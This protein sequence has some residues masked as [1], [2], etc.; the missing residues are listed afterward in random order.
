VIRTLVACLI[1]LMLSVQTAAQDTPFS[2]LDVFQVEYA[3]DVQIAPDG[4]WV[5]YVRNS[6]SI[7]RDRREGRLWMVRTDQS[8]HRQLT[9]GDQT[10]SSPRW[11]PDGSRIAFVTRGDDGA[12]I[13]V[14]WVATGESARLTQLDRSPHDIAWS[15][16]GNFLAFSK[17]VPEAS[18]RLA[19][20]PPRPDGAQWADAPLVE[21]RVHH[22]SDGSGFIE[23]GYN[24]LFV[25]PAD[26]GTPR[27][28]TTGDFHHGSP[29]WMPDGRSILFSANRNPDW[30]YERRESDIYSV[31]VD[32]GDNRR[33]TD[34]RGP[35]SSPAVAPDGSLVAYVGFD[36]RIQTY[37]TT[38]LYFMRSDG[39]R[40]RMVLEDL[41]RSVGSPTWAN[42]GSGVY[43]S[44]DDEGISKVGFV[45]P[46]GDFRVV[47]DSLGGTA[48]GRPYGGG[49]F[50]VA[51]DGS[52]AY[53]FTTSANPS[54]VGLSSPHGSRSFLTALN[55]DLKAQRQIAAAEMF[56]TESSHDGRPVQSW[57]VFPPDFDPSQQYPLILEIHGGPISNYGDRFSAEVQL[58][59]TAG[60]VVV[61]SNPR[62]S[63]S[64]GAEFGNL[65]YHDYPG[66][67]YDDLMSAVDAVIDRGYI[68][69]D[70]LYVTGGSA[71]GIMTAW[72]VGKTHRFRAAVVTKPV[73]N[74]ISKTLVA[75]NYD[76]YMD[77]R[78]PGKP[79]ENPM[80]YW[81]FSPL[82]LVSNI[83]TPTMVMVGTADLR[84]PLSEAKQ[85]YH[86]LKL[87]RVETALV[88]IPGAYHNISNR[89]SQLIA[90]VL[91]AIAWFDRYGG[92]PR[93][94]SD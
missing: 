38:N 88:Q 2:D 5:V 24:H 81:E 94:A 78:Y 33:L 54:E 64:Y 72:I 59:A 53:T 9:S 29:V 87:R 76:G 80:G 74:W 3:S 68:D 51:R 79:W 31:P 56:W 50:S 36:D 28:I 92:Q 35:D 73:V 27:Q 22:E 39:S 86:A 75:D 34:R 57:V 37:Q 47:A 4:D 65:L 85:L 77:Y 61:Y 15:P 32:D 83:E 7:M 14:Y 40:S 20:L 21:T 11:S 70:R 55:E 8:E 17:L 82:S 49:N 12:E 1:C 62:G 19:A 16:D 52:V 67:D 44:Y 48:V 46:E 69:E 23:P 71:G 91:H 60:F 93:P 18:P 13:Y 58:Y 45:T 41:N 90:K 25:I 63:T 26:G 42:D 6:M 43:F 30:E 84:T 66:N 89:P 10:E